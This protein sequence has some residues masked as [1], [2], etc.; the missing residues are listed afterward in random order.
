MNEIHYTRHDKNNIINKLHG[1]FWEALVIPKQQ[2]WTGTD[3]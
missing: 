3:R 2:Q 1:A